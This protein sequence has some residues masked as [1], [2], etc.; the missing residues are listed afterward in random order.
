MRNE[1]T[2]EAGWIDKGV[3][4][5]NMNRRRRRM[6]RRKEGQKDDDEEESKQKG[7]RSCRCLSEPLGISLGR[8][9]EASW[10]ALGVSW[11]SWGSL[12]RLGCIGEAYGV[13]LGASLG[14]LGGFWGGLLWQSWGPLGAAWAPLGAILE[15]I[16]RKRGE[17][18]LALPL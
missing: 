2:G 3:E 8:F 11:R 17:L 1:E 10:G 5:R 7:Q 18:S 13:L 9:L 14:P 12:G 6:R 4:R 16:Y 15:E